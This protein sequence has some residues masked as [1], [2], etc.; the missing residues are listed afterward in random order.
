MSEYNENDIVAIVGTKRYSTKESTLLATFPGK[1]RA[2]KPAAPTIRIYRTAK[3]NY[4]WVVLRTSS[5]EVKPITK[6]K[7]ISLY[8]QATEEAR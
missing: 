7:A 3:G 2:P 4:F 8:Q 5:A 1:A 6:E